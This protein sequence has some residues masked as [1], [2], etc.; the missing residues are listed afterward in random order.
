M[1]DRSHPLTFRRDVTQA[2]LDRFKDQPFQFGKR[3]CVRMCAFHLRA[4]G[5]RPH[6]AKAGSYST[7][8][9]AR[10]ALRAAGFYTLGGAVDGIGLTRI[11]PAAALPGDL[12]EL[13]SE[14]DIGALGIAAGNGR[15][16]GY[17]PDAAGAVIVQP[18]E[19]VAAWRVEPLALQKKGAA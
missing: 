13:P 11:A 6:L 16:L 10:R 8:L 15:L 3:D 1:P 18:T 2:T 7:Y 5:Y 9:G 19:F 14:D 17:H 12:I 4:M